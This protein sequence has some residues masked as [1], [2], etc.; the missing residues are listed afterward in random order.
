MSAEQ[1]EDY[2]KLIRASRQKSSSFEELA[3]ELIS[4]DPKLARKYEERHRQ[5]TVEKVAA[6]LSECKELVDL[7]VETVETML[8]LPAEDA[9]NL[10]QAT[11]AVREAGIRLTKAEI[12]EAIDLA[13]VIHV[14]EEEQYEQA[15]K[16]MIGQVSTPNDPS[17]PVDADYSE[18]MA[19]SKFSMAKRA[20]ARL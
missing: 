4:S 17:G 5:M 11:S 2:R 20:R 1:A 13:R 8:A 15:R 16:Q 10:V 6:N 18:V 19:P 14:M 9:M 3:A 7:P 12:K